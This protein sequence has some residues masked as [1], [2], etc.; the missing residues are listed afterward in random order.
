MVFCLPPHLS[1]RRL[2]TAA[3]AAT[4]LLGTT[5]MPAVAAPSAAVSTHVRYGDDAR[6]S[7]QKHA[8]VRLLKDLFE[9]GD[10]SVVDRFVRP[11]YIQHNPTLPDGSEAVKALGIAVH[12]QFPDVEYKVKRVISEGDLVLV[13]GNLALTPGVRGSAAFD[14]FRF[15]DGKIAEHWDVSQDVPETTA[16]GNDMFSTVS[17]PQINQPIQHRLTKYNKRLVTEA[18]DELMVKKNVTEAV[19]RYFGP[20]YH[21]HSPTIPNGPDGVKDGLGGY[22]AAF[23]ELTNTPKRVI[24]EGDLVAVHTHTVPVPGSRGQ[25]ILD[26]FRVRNGKIVEH[27]DAIQNVPETSV[28]DNTM[29]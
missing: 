11:D 23:P 12:Q 9:Q 28:N 14:I 19:D 13:H 8:A 21:Q 20:E 1:A 10:T 17:A 2:L 15:Q 29:F 18:Y 7:Y 3:L 4:A 22:F 26:V 25:A 27:W 5:A 16:N 24:A 6:S